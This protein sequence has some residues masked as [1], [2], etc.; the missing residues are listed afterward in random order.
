MFIPGFQTILGTKVSEDKRVAIFAI[1]A[2]CVGIGEGLGYYYGTTVG[3]NYMIKSSI[4]T[5]AIYLMLLCGLYLS[6]KLLW[7]NENDK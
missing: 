4:S 7:N 1:N 3:F 2:L 5:V 6:L